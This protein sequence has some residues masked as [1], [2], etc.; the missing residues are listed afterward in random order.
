[1]SKTNYEKFFT[2]HSGREILKEYDLSDYDT[3]EILGEDPNCDIGGPHHKPKLAIVEGTLAQTI[4][5]AVNLKGFWQW[6]AGG[7]IRPYYIPV[8]LKLTDKHIEELE[9]LKEREEE[10][11]EE[12]E[13]VQL[14]IKNAGMK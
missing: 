11:A 8:P 3:W 4:A 7:E 2:T 10:L 13:K 6:G 14:A 12:L 1:M 9:A 5:Y